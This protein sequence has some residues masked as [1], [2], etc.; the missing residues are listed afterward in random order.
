MGERLA[1]QF[2]RHAEASQPVVESGDAGDRRRFLGACCG[3][4]CRA[5]AQ[6]G[7]ELRCH[8]VDRVS[9]GPQIFE[10]VV[11]DPEPCHAVSQLPFD[12]LDELDERQR[13]GVQVVGERRGLVDGGGVDLED[14]R[15]LVRTRSKTSA[16]VNLLSLGFAVWSCRALQVVDRFS[17]A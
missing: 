1:E 4:A 3:G 10:V 8:V 12:G 14:L 15:Q 7:L 16:R 17:L 2:R 9:H 6:A 13:V 11:V 5:Q